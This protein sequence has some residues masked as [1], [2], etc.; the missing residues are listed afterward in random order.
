MPNLIMEVVFMENYKNLP[1]PQ[2]VEAT[3]TFFKSQKYS[4]ITLANYQRIWNHLLE[5]SKNKGVEHYDI[6]IGLEFVKN[7]YGLGMDSMI[8]PYSRRYENFVFRAVRCLSE[9][10]LHG[11]V[12]R[13]IKSEHHIWSCKIEEPFREYL[14]WR[15]TCVKASSQRKEDSLLRRFADYLNQQGVCSLD[16]ITANHIHGFLG[17][18][19]RYIP[20]TINVYLLQVRAFLNF[21]Y[22]RGYSSTNLALLVPKVSYVQVLKIP[23]T[24]T[25]EEIACLLSKVDRANPVGKRDYAILL[26]AVRLG[27]RSGDICK[28]KFS[29][30]HWEANRIEIFQEKSKHSIVLPILNDVGDSIIDYLRNGRPETTSEFV[31]I[32]HFAPYDDIDSAALWQIMVKYLRMANMKFDT[33]KK[34]GMHSLRHSLASAL[35]EEDT[36]LPVISEIL[37]HLNMNTTRIYT[38]IDIKQLKKCALEAPIFPEGGEQ[39]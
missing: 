1:L 35:L 17:T 23:T 25:K 30:F 2:L 15:K 32:R 39:S 21:L 29:N 3:E 26:L 11:M 10:Q 37:G 28:L 19:Q 34:A 9:Y 4:K 36:P 14:Q 31:F 13:R 22:S 6:E 38:N 16:E 33:P 5:Y 20:S 27:I 24:Y 7:K 8:P 12:F 18:L